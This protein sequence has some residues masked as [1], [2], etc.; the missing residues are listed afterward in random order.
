MEQKLAYY[1]IK[2]Q[3]AI[4]TIDHPPMNA[5]DVATK[6]AVG[7]VFR[8]LDDR[9][10]EI[11]AVVLHGAGDSLRKRSDITFALAIFQDFGLPLGND[12]GNVKIND[13]PRLVSCNPVLAGRK[14]C[15]VDCNE[16]DLIRLGHL[17]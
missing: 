10:R 1:E 2:G 17:L 11:R 5:L 13:L 14:R 4:V 8:E 7:E 6:E 16:L 15:P 3:T 9:R 12:S